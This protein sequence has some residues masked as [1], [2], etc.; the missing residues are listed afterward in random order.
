[1][2]FSLFPRQ[3]GFTVLEPT[4]I[5][6][7]I[8]QAIAI[9]YPK[10]L[11]AQAVGYPSAPLTGSSET[12]QSQFIRAIFETWDAWPAQMPFVG[13]SRLHDLTPLRAAFESRQW[14]G[15]P[16][17]AAYW[18]TIGLRVV[19]G[20]GRPKTAY[21]TLRMQALNRGWWR[22]E[23]KPTRPFHLG[24]TPS[25]Y[26]GP[27]DPAEYVSVVQWMDSKLATDAD[28]INLHLDSGV[29]WVEALADDFSSPELPY[30]PAQQARWSEL[31]RHIPAGHK[32]LVSLNPLGIPRTVLAPYFGVG[33]GFSFTED[34]RRIPDGVMK[35]GDNRMPPAPWDGYDLDHPDVK[36]AF[37][38]YCRRAIEFFHP[39][40]LIVAIEI[41][42]T[43]NESVQAYDKFLE[44]QKYVYAH[45]KADPATSAV[46]ILVSIS[47]TSF[48]RDEYGIPLKFEE[49]GG[50]KHDLQV[51]GLIDVLPYVDMVALSLYPH[52]GKYNATMLVGAMYDELLGILEAAG[53]P[54]GISESGWPAETFDLLGFPF[55]STPEKQNTFLAQ[56]FYSLEKST[57]PIEFVIGFSIRDDDYLWNRL[58]QGSQQQPPTVSPTF[59]EFYKY[60]RDIGIYDG[61][62]NPRLSWDLWQQTLARRYAPRPY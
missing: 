39:D 7:Q 34:F 57:L 25:P 48:V 2:S 27:A 16:R 30:S 50:Q 31:R 56:L 58:L 17:A 20:S 43:M 40:Y 32:V 51:Q 21:N 24:F 35:D 49:Q 37:V 42:A 36:K 15:S 45:L 52:Y 61:D 3:N 12:K 6:S 53:K 60:F 29:P 1:V 26:D 4:A 10:P 28:I 46:P 38:S 47:A 11:Y 13:F 33:Q 23:P 18:Q 14:G 8:E 19:D 55:L 44:L 22:Y 59:V 54:I 9:Y 5:R 62:G 41:T